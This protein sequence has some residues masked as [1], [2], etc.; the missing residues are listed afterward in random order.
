FLL[1]TVVLGGYFGAPFFQEKGDKRAHLPGETSHGHYQIEVACAQCH[2]P[3][4]GVR[5]DA[6]TRCHGE[7]LTAAN[8]S[9]PDGKFADP[10]NAERSQALDA[11]SCVTCHREHVP[12]RTHAGVTIA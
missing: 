8:D 10:R 11:R 1:I 12:D 3:F 2:T 6:C 9:H 7:E 5:N 4:G